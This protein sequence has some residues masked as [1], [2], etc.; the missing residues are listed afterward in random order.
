[1]FIIGGRRRHRVAC[2]WFLRLALLVPL[3]ALFPEAARADLM[4]V[5]RASQIEI[6]QELDPDY[7]ILLPDGPILLAVSQSKDQ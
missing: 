5:T 3:A 4:S 1:M 2:L 6:V 7:E